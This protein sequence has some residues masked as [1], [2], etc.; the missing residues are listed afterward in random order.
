MTMK[1]NRVKAMLRAGVSALAAWPLLATS[2]LAGPPAGANDNNTTTPIKHVII[3]V[4]EN[5]SFDHLFGTYKSPSGE[6]VRNI[7]SEAIINA[8][9]TPGRNFAK[10]LQNQAS[11]TT[12]YSISPSITG[13]YATLPPPSTG[14]AS[15]AQS[16]TAPPFPPLTAPFP[17]T[18]YTVGQILGGI[19]PGLAVGG[20][21]DLALLTT[22]AT[23]LPKDT[24]DT[25]IA[26]AQGLKSGPYPLDPAEGFDEYE[27]DPVHRFYQM[28]QQLDC[29]AARATIANPSGCKADLFP[30]VETTVSVGANGG[31]QP[32][33]FTDETT[34][35][36]SLA[37]GFYNVQKGDFPYLK[38]LADS[39]TILDNYH[40]PAKGGTGLDSL[41]LGFADDIWYSDAAGNAATPPANQIENPDPQPGTNNWYT[42]DGYSG[43]SYSNCSDATQPGVGSIVSYLNALHVNPNCASG[44]YYLLNNYNPGYLGS[45]QVLPPSVDPFTIPPSSTPS[46][47]DSLIAAKVSWAYYGEG[48]NTFVANPQSPFDIYCNICNPFLYETSIMTGTDPNTGVPYRQQNLLDL[49]NFYTDLAN[50][51]LPA[52]VYIKPSGL[53][54]GHPQ[55]SKVSVFE[56]FVQNIVSKV[57]ANPTLWASTAIMITFDEGGGFWDSGYVQQIDFFGDG[58]RI[59]M[60]IV[61]PYTTG[62]HVSHVYSDHAS[63]PKFIEANWGLKPITARSRDNLPNPIV[64]ADKPYVPKNRPALSDMMAAFHF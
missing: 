57:Q 48:W 27:N 8:N 44:H 46:I 33:D 45:G 53:N 49:P 7:L 10:A 16:Y 50:N 3:S 17:G 21:A 31:A 30:W 4:G 35:E 61:S 26:H 36:G 52:V 39:Y 59:P 13:P 6:E 28:F 29:S 32:G 62:G 24:I 25:R 20:A 22:G 11:D 55:T 19:D 56:A 9:G 58:T 60:L 34:N 14:G 5:R 54:D 51:A 40:Q 63:V 12:T 41:Y 18:P 43:G 15:P 64:D 2:A 47:A 1:R 37:M 42:Q 23:G 38:S